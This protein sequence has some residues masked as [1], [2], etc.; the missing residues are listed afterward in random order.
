VEEEADSLITQKIDVKLRSLPAPLSRV[1]TLTIIAQIAIAS[2]AQTQRLSA[3]PSTTYN[4][5]RISTIRVVK[6]TKGSQRRVRRPSTPSPSYPAN[7][8]YAIATGAEKRSHRGR[9]I[10][11]PQR[12][13]E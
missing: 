10:A 9:M 1:V 11:L 4:T 3:S 12:F 5:R 6:P 8:A 13:R 7:A 2:N